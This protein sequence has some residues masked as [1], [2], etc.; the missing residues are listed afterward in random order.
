M[1]APPASAVQKLV[2]AE[3]ATTILDHV[4]GVLHRWEAY[5]LFAMIAVVL[6]LLRRRSNGKES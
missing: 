3:E 2:S 5:V 4:L 1:A 6:W